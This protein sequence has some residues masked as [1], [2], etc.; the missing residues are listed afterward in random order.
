MKKNDRYSRANGVVFYNQ[1]H[2]IFCPK[3]RRK[4][5]K[6]DVE[7]DL[8]KII[9]QVAKE[10]GATVKALEVMP[11]HVHLFIYLDPRIKVSQIVQLIKGRSS[12]VLREKYPFLRKMRALWSPSYFCCSI[13]YVSEKTVKMYIKNQ[14]T[15]GGRYEKT[16]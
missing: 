13:G 3:Y 6:W 1:Y 11:D 4:V 9:Y 14:K 10:K 16:N 7:R 15:N 5:L 12:R 2:I 8:R